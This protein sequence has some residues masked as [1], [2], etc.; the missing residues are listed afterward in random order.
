M[1]A[2]RVAR[3]GQPTVL[4]DQGP[5]TAHIIVGRYA[6]R[7]SVGGEYVTAAPKPPLTPEEREVARA[8]NRAYYAAHSAAFIEANRRYRGKVS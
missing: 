2:L 3:R 1:S 8:K 4:I 6:T 5:A 7:G